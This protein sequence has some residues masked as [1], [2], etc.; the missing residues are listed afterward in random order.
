MYNAEVKNTENGK[1]K[2]KWT[3]KERNVP[4]EIFWCYE[5]SR[6]LDPKCWDWCYILSS[7]ISCSLFLFTCLLFTSSQILSLLGLMLIP[8]SRDACHWKSSMSLCSA[9]VC[10]PLNH[11]KIVLD[12]NVNV[13]ACQEERKG[14]QE[15]S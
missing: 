11:C 7:L 1:M 3:I 4:S 10:W 14:E 12:H 8:V 15:R 9:S 5:W 13:V 2:M 6:T